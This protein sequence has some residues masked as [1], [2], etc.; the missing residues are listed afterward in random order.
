[1][2]VRDDSIT[3][4]HDEYGNGTVTPRALLRVKNG[5]SAVLIS[6]L[7]INLK[8]LIFFSINGYLGWE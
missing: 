5:Q 2:T 8:Y 7:L 4:G 6:F 3:I 1:M